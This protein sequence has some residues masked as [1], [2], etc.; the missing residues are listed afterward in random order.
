M[1]ALDFTETPIESF[2]HETTYCA[3]EEQHTANV[4]AAVALGLPSLDR[5]ALQSGPLAV[6]CSGPSLAQTRRDLRHFDYILTCSGAHDYLLRYGIVP[7]WHME[8]DPRP[9]KALFVKHPHK[10]VQYLL[11][12]ACHPKVFAALKGYDVKIWHV[13]RH[14]SDLVSLGKYP[15]GH[16]VLTGGTNVGQRAMVMGRILGFTDIHVFGM[17]CSA[18]ESFHTGDHPNN[19]PQQDWIPVRVGEMT[20]YSTPLFV[21]YAKQFFHEVLQLPDVHVTL[22]GDGLLQAL[23]KQKL[24]DPIQAEAWL[25]ARENVVDTTIA[26]MEFPT[27]MADVVDCLEKSLDNLAPEA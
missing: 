18:G 26:V 15:K 4:Q 17:D 2:T 25:A 1:D 3:S 19:P 22:H 6:V 7:T 14:G 8:G 20:Y 23:A 21:S 13:L 16:W 24:T 27:P 10:R 9:H 11:A 5:G 12:S